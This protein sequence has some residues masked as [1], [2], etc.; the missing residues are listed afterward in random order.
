MTSTNKR[1]IPAAFPE[2]LHHFTR[3][4]IR[5]YPTTVP[6]DSHEWIFRFAVAH[7]SKGSSSGPSGVSVAVQKPTTQ[8]PKSAPKPSP[9]FFSAN[10]L[11]ALIVAHF[12]EA[13]KDNNSVSPYLLG[14]AYFSALHGYPSP[15]PLQIVSTTKSFC[16][17]SNDLLRSCSSRKQIYGVCVINKQGGPASSQ[18]YEPWADLITPLPI[19]DSS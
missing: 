1:V 2:I 11:E 12:R 4:V 9:R 8:R 3:E 13:D 14:I 19:T 18:A 7:F 17:L 5:E 16:K 15:P 10:E 6:K